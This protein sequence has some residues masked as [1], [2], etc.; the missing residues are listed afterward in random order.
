LFTSSTEDYRY[1]SMS[2]PTKD[3]E[4]VFSASLL[5]TLMK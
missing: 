4:F 5:N 2:D 1:N 3:I